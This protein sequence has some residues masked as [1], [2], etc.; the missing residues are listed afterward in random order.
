MRKYWSLVFALFIA[1]AP[2]TGFAQNYSEQVFKVVVNDVRLNTLLFEQ[3]KKSGE[4]AET[5]AQVALFSPAIEIADVRNPEKTN[6]E[7]IDFLTDYIKANIEGTPEHVLGYWQ[8]QETA[9]QLIMD[10]ELFAKNREITLKNPSLKILGLIK[11]KD[12]VVLLREYSAGMI[13]GFPLRKING[14]YF[15]L[16]QPEDDLQLA[17]IEASL[18]K[19][20]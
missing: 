19:A 4:M 12:S 15:I 20:P 8:D 2:L 1:F 13:G 11:Q 16:S 3:G 17:I 9:K 10:K 5:R 18:R 14:R 7:E 6:I